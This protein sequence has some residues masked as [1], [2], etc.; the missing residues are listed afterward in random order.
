MFH[1]HWYYCHCNFI[2]EK[3]T[4]TED[5]QDGFYSNWMKNCLNSNVS[6]LKIPKEGRCKD[7][8]ISPILTLFT[9][10]VMVGIDKTL[11]CHSFY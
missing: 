3:L 7:I 2:N 6:S 4:G 9:F 11:M 1:Q 5:V 8:N 10:K